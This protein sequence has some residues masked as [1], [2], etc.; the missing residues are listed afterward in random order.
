[1]ASEDLLKKAVAA[2]NA[3]SPEQ[4][5][6]M[7][8]EQRQSWVRGNVGLS[9]DERGMTSPVMPQPTT[10]MVSELKPWRYE[11]KYGPDG[12]DS[13]S[14]VYDDQGVMVAPMRTHKAKEVVDAM[15]TRPAP[16]ATDTGLETVAGVSISKKFYDHLDALAGYFIARPPTPDHEFVRVCNGDLRKLNEFLNNINSDELVTRSQAVELLAAERARYVEASQRATNE[17]SLR[18]TM[19]RGLRRWKERAEKAEA[20]NAALTARVKE[21]EEALD[22]DPSGSDLWRYWSR[23]AREASQKYV[24]EVDRAEALEAKL[25]AAEKALEPFA[26]HANDRA[27]DDTGWRDKETVKI[28]VSIGDLRKA[29]AV[30]EGKLS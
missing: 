18:D 19:H 3:L 15:N 28:V 20:D 29:R 11:I 9:R 23:K 2:F 4:Q 1:M 27:V 6:E 24:D 25:A 10:V 22:S 12:E 13:Y 26:D 21:M 7:M 8:E 14:W 17:E 16:A 30:L 5:A